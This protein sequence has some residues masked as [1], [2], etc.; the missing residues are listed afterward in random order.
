MTITR[1]DLLRSTACTVAGLAGLRTVADAQDNRTP[2]GGVSIQLVR[3]A[4]CIIRYGGKAILL[5]PMLS[6]AGAMPAIANSPNPRRNPLVPLALT[7]PAI[8]SATDATLVTHTHFD[9]WDAPTAG[10]L[11]KARTVF[12]Q[13]PDKKKLDDAGFTDVRVLT[14]SGDWEGLTL[15]RV[16]GQH[17]RGETGQRMGPVSGYVLTKAGLPTLYIAGD[18]VWCPEVE[19]AIRTHK[20]DVILVNAGAAQFLE[21]GPITMDVDDV[22]TVIKAAPAARIVAVHM[23]AINHCVLT[24]DALRSGLS[25]AAVKATILIPYD[26]DLVPIA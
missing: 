1:R 16:G 3:H 20:P 7:A 21:G 13:T 6:E 15:T 4:T 17:G 8:I 26:G 11:P 22:V 2:A 9:H 14:T 5:D 23:E 10:L 18:S 24:R 12:V 25:K 19:E